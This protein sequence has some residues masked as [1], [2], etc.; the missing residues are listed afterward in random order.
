MRSRTQPS[1][2]QMWR[3]R[4]RPGK[5][6]HLKETPLSFAFAFS[7]SSI[8]LRPPILFLRSPSNPLKTL[9][10]IHRPGK[11]SETD[12]SGRRACLIKALKTDFQR[13]DQHCDPGNRA[14]SAQESCGGSDSGL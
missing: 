6:N 9:I 11:S 4:V 1:F 10:C 14:V 12:F 5:H 7:L 3:S 13:F 8:V 2:H